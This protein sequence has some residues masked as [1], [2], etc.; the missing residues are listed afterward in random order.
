[1]KR[2]ILA[3][4]FSAILLTF[5][6][7][8][9]SN[10]IEANKNL[11]LKNSV[12]SSLASNTLKIELV[13]DLYP[14]EIR[15]KGAEICITSTDQPYCYQRMDI[16]KFSQIQSKRISSD[17]RSEYS[18]LNLDE[19]TFIFQFT[20]VGKFL[21]EIRKVYYKDSNNEYDNL[22][23]TILIPLEITD[24]S[25]G[26]ISIEDLKVAGIDFFVQPVLNC[27]EVRKSTD[28]SVAC[29]V[30]YFYNARSQVSRNLRLLVQPYESFRICA[31]RGNPQSYGC[32]N[33]KPYF[34]KDFKVDLNR[35]KK[36]EVPVQ[37]D[38]LSSIYLVSLNSKE[39]LVQVLGNLIS[40]KRAIVKNGTKS[41]RWIRQCKNVTVYS[42]SNEQ[43]RIEDGR[44]Q[45]GSVRTNMKICESVWMP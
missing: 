17:P 34:V 38:N 25:N 42:Q 35:A 6:P 36:I 22:R 1:M 10:V 40:D 30:N 18:V 12:P 33:G 26:G 14:S 5:M 8:A 27:P 44:I 11:V 28:S 19:N 16:E 32:S 3:S 20:S 24:I 43:M 2:A 7:S 4:I 45:G 9:T 41:G 21:I 23:S 37:R 31:Y 13:S 29:E 15:Y 39:A